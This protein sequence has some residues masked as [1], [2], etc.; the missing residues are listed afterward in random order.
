MT[1]VVSDEGTSSVIPT[2]NP[3]QKRYFED[4]SGGRRSDDKRP[5]ETH[6]DGLCREENERRIIFKRNCRTCVAL[7]LIAGM[8]FEWKSQG[9]IE[10]SKQDLKTSNLTYF[11]F[12]IRVDVCTHSSEKLYET[13][14]KRYY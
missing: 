3:I 6:R 12:E 1:L 2:K 9:S 8:D 11:I 4:Q 7:L 5:N 10:A 13:L 14:Y